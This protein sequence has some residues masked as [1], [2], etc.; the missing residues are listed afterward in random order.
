MQSRKVINAG[1]ERLKCRQ[2]KAQRQAG[3]ERYKG[4]LRKVHR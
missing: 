4:R 3:K 2:G 1:K